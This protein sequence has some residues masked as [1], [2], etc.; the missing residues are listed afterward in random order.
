MSNLS[1]KFNLGLYFEACCYFTSDRRVVA[2]LV[3]IQIQ[4]II[5]IY[6]F[7]MLIKLKNNATI[8]LSC[9]KL[10]INKAF[11]KQNKCNRIT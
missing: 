7:I 11:E 8:V 6:L 9:F 5:I 4:I 2:V 3:V 1:F 10:K